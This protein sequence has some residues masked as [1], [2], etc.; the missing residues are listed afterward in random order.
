LNGGIIINTG[1]VA[2]KAAPVVISTKGTAK[3]KT[4]L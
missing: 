1:V 3:P 4:L 2:D